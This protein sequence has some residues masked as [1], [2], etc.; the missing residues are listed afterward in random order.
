MSQVSAADPEIVTAK[1]A[2]IPE[3]TYWPFFLA[4]GLAFAGWGLLSTWIVS[5]GGLIAVVIALIGWINCLR[6]E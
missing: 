1:P 4:L 6:H 3:P 2:R 5:V